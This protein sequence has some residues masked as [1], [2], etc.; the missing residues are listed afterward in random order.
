MFR[1]M[2]GKVSKLSE[3]PLQHYQKEKIWYFSVVVLKAV[4]FRNLKSLQVKM[5]FKKSHTEIKVGNYFKMNSIH[6]AAFQFLKLI[7][8]CL[9]TSD[10]EI[11]LPSVS[12]P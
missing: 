4:L 2:L 6:L 1:N 3:Y 7:S 10:G 11:F 12:F 9:S 5:N 8:L